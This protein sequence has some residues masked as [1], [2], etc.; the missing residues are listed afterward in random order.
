MIFVTSVLNK[1]KNEVCAAMMFMCGLH[2]LHFPVKYLL[3]IQ[4]FVFRRD[5]YKSNITP[6]PVCHL[7]HM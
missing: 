1:K 5:S 4:F 7:S 3:H 2:S 6:F